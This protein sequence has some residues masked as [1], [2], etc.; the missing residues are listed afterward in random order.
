MN[1]RGHGINFNRTCITRVLPNPAVGR[2]PDTTPSPLDMVAKKSK[3]ISF[4]DI[5]HKDNSI[6][7]INWVSIGQTFLN[8]AKD[9]AK[10]AVIVLSE[11]RYRHLK[12]S[13][14]VDNNATPVSTGMPYYLPL[15]FTGP[16]TMI[17][18]IDLLIV[19][20]ANRHMA[21]SVPIDFDRQQ[22]E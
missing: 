19:N 10:F 6:V 12:G 22:P 15:H 2:K 4:D 7:G 9:V 20:L 1:A 18:E 11:A 3:H 21:Y 5:N 13:E 8:V 14:V 16:Y 17:D